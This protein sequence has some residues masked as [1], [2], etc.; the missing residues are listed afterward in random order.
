MVSIPVVYP[1]FALLESALGIFPGRQ[2]LQDDL[3]DHWTSR[4]HRGERLRLI[5]RLL[6]FSES[7]ECRV[8]L[9][10]GDVHV[11]A[12]GTIESRRK[13]SRGDNTD[14][15][16]Q[17]ISSPIV[18]VPPPGVVRFFLDQ[19][20]GS[21]EE[22]DRG[23]VGRILQFPTTQDRFLSSRNWLSLM[24]DEDATAGDPFRIWAQWWVESDLEHPYTKVIHPC[25]VAA[26]TGTAG[27][28][29]S[30]PAR[31][32]RSTQTRSGATTTR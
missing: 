24:P 29:S 31:T 14:V 12:C 30:R 10:S 32:A 17:L 23:I 2:D 15:I 9:I 11:A 5:H 3:R 21:E 16:T 22:I 20:G 1:G 26:P 25:T 28:A 7:K 27:R 18:H 6:A 19:R 13:P 8:T 4:P